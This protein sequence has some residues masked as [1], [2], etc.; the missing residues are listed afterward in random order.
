MAKYIGPKCKLARREKM[1]LDLKSGV[2]SLA[3]KCNLNTTPGEH[4]F[5]RK[6]LTNYG[7][8]LREKQKIKRIYGMME[9]K[10]KKTYLASSKM[11]GNTG[12]NFLFLLE[13]RLDNTVFRMGFAKTRA[14]ARQIVSHKGII[15]NGRCCNIASRIL[16]PGDVVELKEKNK[17]HIYIEEALQSSKNGKTVSWLDINYE[18]KVGKFLDMPNREELSKDINEKLVVDFYSGNN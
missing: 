18:E 4:G 10:F 5:S 17:S 13:R 7:T 12:E 14:H 1:D 11:L 9:R 6:R 15:V 16:S 3:E 8:Q 2:R